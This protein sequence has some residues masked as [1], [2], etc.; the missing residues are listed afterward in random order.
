[1]EGSAVD[2]FDEIVD[3]E[4]GIEPARPQV[5][6]S[7]MDLLAAAGILGVM[8]GKPYGR[9]VERLTVKPCRNALDCR[10]EVRLG[11]KFDKISVRHNSHTVLLLDESL[12]LWRQSDQFQFDLFKR[13]SL[14]F[15]NQLPDK[16]PYNTADDRV[17]AED[18]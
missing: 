16:H 9:P 10:L 17:A 14:G 12:D 8:L 13:F 18:G 4:F 11:R 6:P 2:R 15:G 1:M 3:L 7:A 5:W